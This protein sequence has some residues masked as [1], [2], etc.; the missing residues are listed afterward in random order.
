ME[1][2]KRSNPPAARVEARRPC[3]LSLEALEPRLL[4]D[5][6]TLPPATCPAPEAY[7]DMDP[8]GDYHYS[9]TINIANDVDTFYFAPDEATTP[10]NFSAV[11]PDSTLDTRLALYDSSLNSTGDFNDDIGGGSADSYFEADIAGSTGYV[12][13][14]DGYG[15]STGSYQILIDTA[16]PDIWTNIVVHDDGAGAMDAT[17]NWAGDHD[18]WRVTAPTGMN[19]LHA[20]TTGDTHT[21]LT[22]YTYDGATY[23]PIAQDSAAPNADLG[24]PVNPGQDY[25]I[26]L[27]GVYDAS[28]NTRLNVDFDPRPDL[29]GTH[30]HADSPV[31]WGQAFNVDLGVWNGGTV[32][33]GW[34]AAEFYLSNDATFGDGDDIFLGWQG[35]DPLAP[36]G[37]VMSKGI[38]L[39]MPG[40]PGAGYDMASDVYIGV[41][42]DGAALVTES[43]EV[44]NANRG[45]GLDQDRVQQSKAD[46][47]GTHF[48]ADGPLAWGQTFYV[49]AG[50]WNGGTEWSGWAPVEFYLSDD[51]IFGNPDDVFL[52][53]QG[54]DP[55]APYGWTLINDRALVL[56]DT[57]PAGYSGDI[58]VGMV[59]DRAGL[60]GELS[61]GNN[62]NQGDGLDFVQKTMLLPDLYCT[63]FDSAEPL[64][65]GET[66]AVDT[67]VYNGGDAWSGWTTVD[68]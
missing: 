33:S 10:A 47:V 64:H 9:S 63:S 50:L 1:S 57:M 68:V 19:Y 22:V 52:G 59:I 49:D 39:T 46:L 18:F 61:E 32:W 35:I 54:V 65:W 45:E 58:Y 16:A 55:L 3:G 60:V 38:A 53:W 6:S 17:M 2:R 34:T 56:P 13:R 66:F 37:W 25:Y 40:G 5:G 27:T 29:M 31:Q 24:L 48:N 51:A 30:F 4:L 11:T 7:L 12:L 43:N 28:G 44:N 26:A 42:L 23:T 15:T 62:S 8:A 20:W 36:Y 14:V 41:I 67:G 21:K